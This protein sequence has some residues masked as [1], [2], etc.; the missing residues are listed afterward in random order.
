MRIA[1]LGNFVV[2]YTSESHHAKSLESLGHTVI[3][4]QEGQSPTGQ[5][6]KQALRSQLFCWTH[7]H[8]WNVLGILSMAQ[9]LTE[10]RRQGIPSIAY[11]LDLFYGLP[12]RWKTY[13]NE[14]YIRG[15]DYFFTVDGPLADW[16]NANTNVKGHYLPPG[17]LA[18]EAYCAIPTNRF[19]IG[20]VGSLRYHPEWPHRRQLIEW[21]Q[22][23][24]GQRFHLYGQ[25]AG[26]VVR[27]AELNQVYANCRIAIGDSFC[28]NYNYGRYFSDR[29]IDAP[30]RGVF[31]IAPRVNG[32]TDCLKEGTETIL[33][34]FGNFDQLHELIEHYLNNEG[35]RENIRFAGHERVKSEHLYIHRWETILRE[36]FADE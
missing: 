36:V 20:F 35:E 4:I 33:Y 27:G 34:D 28:P 24:Y 6:L 2:D 3:R 22:N 15:L 16:L 8:S 12:E 11:H 9:V 7:T 23:T 5:I 19:D 32:I 26:R 1:L 31:Q 14:L 17:I 30:G 18:E 10:L 13:Q 25:D 29:L 21:L